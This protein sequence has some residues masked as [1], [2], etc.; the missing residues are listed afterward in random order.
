MTKQAFPATC[1]AD[2]WTQ[3]V[4][5]LACNTVVSESVTLGK[6]GHHITTTVFPPTCTTP[7]Y[8]LRKCSG[9]PLEERSDYVDPTGHQNTREV[10]ATAGSCIEDAYEAGV[11]C[12][13]CKTYIS[14]HY[15]LGKNRNNHVGGWETCS[16]PATCTKD[17]YTDANR[18]LG[19]GYVDTSVGTVQPALGHTWNE[20]VE[21]KKPTCTDTGIRK[22]TCSTCKTTSVEVIDKLG[23]TDTDGDEICDRCGKNLNVDACPYCNK[24]HTGLFAPLVKLFHKIF[25]LISGPKK[26]KK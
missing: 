2:G 8:T 19:C 23:H 4:T 6:T 24:I 20:G 21:M 7:G 12:D 11:Y 9:C 16:A 1:E 18:C 10:A 5:C 22:F 25:Y 14:G 15:S 26:A 13:D 3:E 17:G